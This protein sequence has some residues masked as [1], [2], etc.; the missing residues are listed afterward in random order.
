[1]FRF[2][3]RIRSA[4]RRNRVTSVGFRAAAAAAARGAAFAFL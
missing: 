3:A 1:M 2:A 4:P